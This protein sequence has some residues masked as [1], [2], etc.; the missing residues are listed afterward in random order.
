MKI[1]S[2]KKISNISEQVHDF[3]VKDVHHYILDNNVVSHNSFFP[4]K[5]MSGGCL[6]AGTKIRTE[7]G[8]QSIETISEGTK[9]LTMDGSYKE[10]L[11]KHQFDNKKLLEIEFEDGTIIRCSED[12]KFLINGEWIEARN[13]VEN[14]DLEVI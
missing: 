7:Y 13:L 3:T 4:M 9:V 1:I 6:I 2:N 14:D 11:Q 8:L 12:H 10:V 5:E